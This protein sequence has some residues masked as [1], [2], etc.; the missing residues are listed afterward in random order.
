MV[1]RT[2]NSLI[3]QITQSEISLFVALIFALGNLLTFLD[4]NDLGG[5]ILFFIVAFLIMMKSK[6]MVI[7]LGGAIIIT[8]IT[9][10]ILKSV[11]LSMNYPVGIEGF[12]EGKNSSNKKPTT[13]DKMQAPNPEPVVNA[14][15][16][17]D[18]DD[19]EE[20]KPKKKP[21]KSLSKNMTNLK[22]KLEASSNAHPKENIKVATEALSK[23]EPLMDRAEGLMKMFNN[24]GGGQMMDSFLGGSE[25][26]E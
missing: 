3:K 20:K 1:K 5:I 22:K 14:T 18:D 15:K 23:L 26:E 2:T 6:N 11:G 25:E 8:N 4:N 16:T 13:N 7:V 12:K 10:I 9:V 19:E 24:M 17:E 21:V